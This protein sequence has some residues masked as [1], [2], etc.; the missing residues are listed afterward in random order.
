M[1]IGLTGT[2]SLVLAGDLVGGHGGAADGQRHLLP[3]GH[4]RHHGVLEGAFRL[5]ISYHSAWLCG[6]FLASSPNFVRIR[7]QISFP[8]LTIAQDLITK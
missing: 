4:D 1:Y 6:K 5:G 2:S 3:L 8:P 7:Y